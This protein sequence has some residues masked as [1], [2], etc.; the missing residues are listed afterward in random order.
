[1][2]LSLRVAP[3]TDGLPREVASVHQKDLGV[4]R[5]RGPACHDRLKR[6]IALKVLVTV[7]Q[8]F[9]RVTGEFACYPT[10]ACKDS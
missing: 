2:D 6:L 5:G 4:A 9:T 1:M 8:E 10:G 3:E 7:C